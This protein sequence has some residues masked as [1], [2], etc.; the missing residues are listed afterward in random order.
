M[1]LAYINTYFGLMHAHSGC[2]TCS[3]AQERSL[4][5]DYH[6]T[7]RYGM[8]K[9]WFYAIQIC[10]QWG[11]GFQIYHQWFYHI[12]ILHNR[13]FSCF[14]CLYSL[15][16]QLFK[17]YITEFYAI[18][19]LHQWLLKANCSPFPRVVRA[20]T[21]YSMALSHFSGVSCPEMLIKYM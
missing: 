9:T 14:H 8:Q 3:Q 5:P 21:M 6:L 20:D 10:H 17:F 7:L 12:Q 19:I 11:Y 2:L 15:Y 16:G 18:Q 4:I 1:Q 13:I